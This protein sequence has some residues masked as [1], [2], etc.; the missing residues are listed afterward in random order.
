MPERSCPRFEEWRRAIDA[1][2]V[3]LVFADAFLNNPASMYGHTFLRL[4]RTGGR[5]GEDLL[6]YTINFAATPDGSNAAL[7]ALKGLVGAFPGVFSTMP[8]YMK[9]QEYNNAESRDLWEYRLAWGPGRVDRL[10]RHAWELGSTHFDYYFFSENC[11]YQLL[12]LLEAAAPELRLSERFGF[13]VIPG[14]TLRA[15]LEQPGLV[16]S[17]RYRPSHATEMRLRRERLRASELAMA[18]RLG[19]GT[20]PAALPALSRL[21]PARQALVL[22]SAHDLLRYRIGFAP[23][24]PPEL[25]RAERRLLLRR[26]SLQLPSPPLEG[27]PRPAPPESGHAS[28]RAGL[29]GGASTLGPFTDLHWRGALHDLADA[30]AGYVPDHELEMLDVRLRL[31]GRRRETYFETL[32]LVNLVS[33]SPLDPWVRRPSWRFATGADQARE[34]GCA[35]WDCAYYYLRGGAG[36]AASTALLGRETWYLLAA[37]DLGL[38]PVFERGWRGGGGLLGGLRVGLGP[39]GR[40]L[41]EGSRYWY[42][43]KPG[44]ESLKLTQAFP[45]ARRLEVRLMLERRPPVSEVSAALLGYF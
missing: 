32:D 31:D 35:G 19:T 20:D 37:A 45:V 23:E 36:L 26:G 2:G 25:K 27:I 14:D 9:I 42:P 44:R 22:D 12:T 38:G 16:G 33:L 24:Q 6:D 30:E 17:R 1:D 8:Y 21:T 40:A 4:H 29:G 41:L 13:G 28:M 39:L 18:T 15:V 5:E 43:E 11:S 7:Y 3:S 34:R 10:L